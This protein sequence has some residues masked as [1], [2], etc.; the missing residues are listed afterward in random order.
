M[1]EMENEVFP[2]N[3]IKKKN[4]IMGSNKVVEKPFT[5]LKTYK[6]D[7]I[8]PYMKEIVS[9]ILPTENIAKY[10]FNMPTHRTI[11]NEDVSS[12]DNSSS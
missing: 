9:E 3:F 6:G 11:Y 4:E 12:P 1:F 8:K 2:T 5:N 7:E 10:H